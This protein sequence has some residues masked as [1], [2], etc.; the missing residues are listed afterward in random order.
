MSTV[1]R[2]LR[3]GP[4]R[5]N[6]HIVKGELRPASPRG[7]DAEMDLFWAVL[8]DD[9]RALTASSRVPVIQAYLLSDGIRMRPL[10]LSQTNLSH[11]DPL[12]F[13]RVCSMSESACSHQS[14]FY[15][16]DDE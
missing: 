1:V 6:G 12:R 11:T 7:P 5:K 15:S 3:I 8:P 13:V 14:R 16:T 4:G 10:S 2:G 9:G